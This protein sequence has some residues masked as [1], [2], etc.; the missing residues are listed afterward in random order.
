MKQITKLFLALFFVSA[1]LSCR[2]T[3]REETELNTAIEEV[4]KMEVEIENV[5]NDLNEATEALEESL[6]ELDSI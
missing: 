1:I 6:Q 4:E 3:K 5:S 2:D